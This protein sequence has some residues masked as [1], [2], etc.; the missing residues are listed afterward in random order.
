M[1]DQPIAP[2][3]P[4]L[5]NVWRNLRDLPSSLTISGITAG[6]IIVL[7]NYTGPLLIVLQAAAAAQLTPAQTSSWVWALVIGNGVITIVMSLLFRMP[8]TAPYTTAGAALLVVSLGNYTLNEA[9]GAYML[10]NGAVMLL[11]LSGLFGR[12]MKLIPAPVILAVLAGVLLRFGLNIF[13]AID[14]APGNAILITAMVIVFFTLKRL[15]FRAPTL[16]AI[17]VGAVI[18]AL[19]G[20]LDFPPL[21]L[22][23][24]LPQFYLPTFTLDAALGLALPLFVMSVSSQYAPGQAVLVANGYDAPIDR[25]L[26]ISGGWSVLMAFFGGHGTTLGALSA[27]VV[28]GPDAQPDPT[29]RYA[30]AIAGGAWHVV[31]GLFGAAVIDLFGGFPGVFVSTIAGLSLSGVIA[32]SLA[33]AM[34]QPETRD[35]ALVAFLCTAGDF[36]LLGIGA[37]FW[38]L[39]AGV[40]VHVLMT[41]RRN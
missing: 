7:I 29:K 24:A 10:A 40:G 1:I 22:A 14:D 38:G 4:T 19:Q 13:N 20:T 5:A 3:A 31:F 28:V 37:P 9:I 34:D 33:G 2:T 21:S 41:W 6:F 17:A 26:T 25:I 32:S 18:A 12:V 15:K 11:G 23:I 36:A 16:G 35:A 30:S 39:L 8:I 27:A